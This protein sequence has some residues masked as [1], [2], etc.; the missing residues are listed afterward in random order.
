VAICEDIDQIGFLRRLPHFHFAGNQSAA[1]LH[2][3]SFRED[4]PACAVTKGQYPF[5]FERLADL[6]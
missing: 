5:Y 3:R 1:H 4:I 6:A 2:H